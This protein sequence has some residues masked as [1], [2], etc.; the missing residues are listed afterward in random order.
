MELQIAEVERRIGITGLD[1]VL[2]RQAFT[3]RSLTEGD[4]VESNSIL[5]LLGSR[6]ISLGIVEISIEDGSESTAAISLRRNAYESLDSLVNAIARLGL[7]EYL[8]ASQELFLTNHDN[9]LRE[10][11]RAIVAVIYRQFGMVAVKQFLKRT[12]VPPVDSSIAAPR[13]PKSLLQ[14]RTNAIWKAKLYYHSYR[15]VDLEHKPVWTV[16]VE[17]KNKRL[18][19]GTAG[20]RKSAEIR[21][22]ETALASI[23]RTLEEHPEYGKNPERLLRAL[24]ES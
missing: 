11:F 19:T 16:S 15:R 1:P 9:A 2:L 20:S 21:A 5:A 17:V 23:E 10:V 14:E 6:V 24:I 12:I 18:A 8:Q 3:H 7:A 13:H 22:A 4:A